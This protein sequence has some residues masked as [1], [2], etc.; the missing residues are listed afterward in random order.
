MLSRRGHESSSSSC[1]EEDIFDEEMQ[2]DNDAEQE[3]DWQ[4]TVNLVCAV[5][6]TIP[7]FDAMQ[8]NER[9][10]MAEVLT[11]QEFEDGQY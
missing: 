10:L 2:S 5:V 7:L 11:L 1:G 8:P 9:E 6:E 3:E 4:N